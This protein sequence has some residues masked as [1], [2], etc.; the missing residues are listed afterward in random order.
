M[1]P[2]PPAPVTDIIRL[3]VGQVAAGLRLWADAGPRTG[4][5]GVELVIATGWLHRPGFRRHALRV[6]E[7][8]P[9]RIGIDWPAA[10]HHAEAVEADAVDAAL[11]RLAASL[12]GHSS[13]EPLGQ[14]L[15]GLDRAAGALVVRALANAV[16]LEYS[17]PLSGKHLAPGRLAVTLR[18]AARPPRPQ[19][20]PPAWPL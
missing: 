1:P 16:G 4:E 2:T 12:A 10:V 5:A 15:A 3:N 7:D 18:D 17:R 6:Q 19:P 14:L 9:L 13:G 20:E 8:D 11:L